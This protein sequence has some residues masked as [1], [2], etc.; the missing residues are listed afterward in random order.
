MRTA[1]SARGDERA[2]PNVLKALRKLARIEFCDINNTMNAVAQ[3]LREPLM[4]AANV[5]L[6]VLGQEFVHD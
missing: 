3:P 2:N 4:V 1:A 6:R 5:R